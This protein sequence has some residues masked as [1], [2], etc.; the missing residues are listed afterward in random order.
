MLCRVPLPW[1][2]ASSCDGSR[3]QTCTPCPPPQLWN[4]ITDSDLGAGTRPFQ[5][6]GDNGRG[7]QCGSYQAFWGLSADAL[8]PPPPP[9]P[10]A[11]GAA[12]GPDLNFV[13]AGLSAAEPTTSNW[14]RERMPSGQVRPRDIYKAMRDRRLRVG[15]YC[16]A[17]GGPNP[18]ADARAKRRA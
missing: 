7:P 4:L 11:G 14:H 17:P 12:F 10:A 15:G 1:R 2:M 18:A 16:H 5:S 6:G 13:A 8:L 9:D 3:A